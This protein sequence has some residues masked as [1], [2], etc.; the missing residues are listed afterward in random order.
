MPIIALLL[1]LISCTTLSPESYNVNRVGYKAA[2]KIEKGLPLACEGI[3]VAKL[4]KNAIFVLT[5][6]HQTPMTIE[7][8]RYF[9]INSVDISSQTF[10]ED[11]AIQEHLQE[12]PFGINNLAIF[13]YSEHSNY[14][15]PPHNLVNC[16]SFV[17]GRIQ[18]QQFDQQAGRYNDFYEETYEEALQKCP[19]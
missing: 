18:Y 10:Q 5:F 3:G 17:K 13:I 7:E 9:L 14:I 2:K 6:H 8:A 12:S 1:L 16:A 19:L 4:E 11:Q 15:K